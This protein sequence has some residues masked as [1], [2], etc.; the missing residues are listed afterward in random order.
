MLAKKPHPGL[1]D[2]LSFYKKREPW[3]V[4]LDNGS[5][6]EPIQQEL[7]LYERDKM[8]IRGAYGLL[9]KPSP[10]QNNVCQ[11]PSTSTI[12]VDLHSQSENPSAEIVHPPYRSDHKKHGN[13]LINRDMTLWRKFQ[14]QELDDILQPNSFTFTPSEEAESLAYRHQ[15]DVL[16]IEKPPK[17]KI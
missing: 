14:R 13:T 15:F 9:V 6:T 16:P 5:N 7:V 17:P 2:A 10:V 3:Q 4:A 1:D 11:L 12:K 8:P